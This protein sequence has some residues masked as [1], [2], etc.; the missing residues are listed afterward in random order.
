[1]NTRDTA[2]IWSRKPEEVH[3]PEIAAVGRAD[4]LLAR[5]RRLRPGAVHRCRRV[6]D[7]APEQVLACCVDDVQ[8]QDQSGHEHQIAIG[9]DH[10][11]AVGSAGELRLGSDRLPGSSR[12]H[13]AV[14]GTRQERADDQH[15]GPAGEQTRRTCALHELAR[16]YRPEPRAKTAPDADQ[17]EEALSL[18]LREH[19]GRKR[20]ELGDDHDVEDA[21]P[22]EIRDADVHAGREQ[23]QE[24][25]EV[26]RKEQRHPL[27][28]LRPVHARRE[29][30]VRGNQ[31]EQQQRLACRRVALH[32]GAALA[33]DEDLARR[34]EQVI[35]RRAR[36]TWSA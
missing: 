12:G 19:I 32:L 1:M 2:N 30:A 27:H 7:V 21:Q 31:H 23:R 8:Q 36:G 16:P 18:F 22:E 5:G 3:V 26:G 11:E 33:E 28:Q 14:D 15:G 13:R 34:L 20:P 35:A 4:E 6:H 29:G 17:R 9:H 25:E 10:A 24:D